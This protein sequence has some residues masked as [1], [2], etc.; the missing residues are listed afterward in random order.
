MLLGL[1]SKTITHLSNISWVLALPFSL[2]WNATKCLMS[3]SR[4]TFSSGPSGD[5]F[6]VVIFREKNKKIW[7]RFFLLQLLAMLQNIAIISHFNFFYN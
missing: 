3:F 5:S 7:C 6:Y 1:K 2:L 4:S